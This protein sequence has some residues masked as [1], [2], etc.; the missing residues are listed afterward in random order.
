[1]IFLVELVFNVVS[2]SGVVMAVVVTVVVVIRVFVK[3][4]G[5]GSG[6]LLPDLLLC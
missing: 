2:P 1:V 6:L 5:G 3:Y 4:L